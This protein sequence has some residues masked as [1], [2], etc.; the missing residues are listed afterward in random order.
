MTTNDISTEKLQS[1]SKDGIS[2]DLFKL[3]WSKDELNYGPS[4][5]IPDTIIYKY[6]TPVSWY[7]TSTNGKIKKKLKQNEN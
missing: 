6:G 4:I 2:E 5:N 1:L 3:L 7:F